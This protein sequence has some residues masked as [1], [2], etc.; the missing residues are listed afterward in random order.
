V[1]GTKSVIYDFLVVS[2]TIHAEVRPQT[3]IK[4]SLDFLRPTTTAEAFEL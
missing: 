3:Y 4:Y 2:A 1:L